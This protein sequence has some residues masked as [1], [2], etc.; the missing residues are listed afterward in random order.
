MK[1]R[2]LTTRDGFTWIE[3]LVV[4]A[5]IGILVAL[6]L[7]A[8]QA[9]RESARRLQCQSNLR[10]L[11][12]GALQYEGQH[13]CLPPGASNGNS[14]F[15]A[16]LPHLE[17]EPLK[18]LFER[19]D[20]TTRPE[21]RFAEIDETVVPIFLCPSDGAPPRSHVSAN[22][23]EA[24]TNYAGNCGTWYQTGNFDGPFR[25]WNDPTFPHTGPPIR[26][27]EVTKGASNVAAFSEFL[28]SHTTVHRLRVNW[29]FPQA[30]TDIDHFAN[31][32][33]GLPADPT[34]LGIFPSLTRGRPW[35][36]PAIA[37]TLYNHVCTPNMPSCLDQGVFM[38]AA[39]TAASNHAG[40]VNVVFLD[41]HIVPIPNGIDRAA[42][43]GFASR[44]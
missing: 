14:V 13:G 24:G 40:V 3:L 19:L 41:G 7:P 8:V 25:H 18:S 31:E 38:F 17:Q 36:Q 43:R 33:E 16:L 21:I 32:C 9:A 23:W 29:I 35:R 6:L 42:W 37:T 30:N 34:T 1:P 27:A 15:V 39:A 12:L 44:Y 2:Q 22:H 20:P 28:R 5:I 4:I 26:L 11:L 10:Q